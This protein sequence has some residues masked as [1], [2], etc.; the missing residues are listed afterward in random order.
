MDAFARSWRT[1]TR[2]AGD[3]ADTFAEGMATRVNSDLTFGILAKELDDIVTLTE[4][5]HSRNLEEIQRFDKVVL[6]SFPVITLTHSLR[7][8]RLR[9]IDLEE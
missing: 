3:R 2:V 9:F 7:A 5:D 1:G 4:C 8:P 6:G